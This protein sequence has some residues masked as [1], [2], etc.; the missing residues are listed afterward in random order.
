MNANASDQTFEAFLFLFMNH[1]E[2]GE[3]KKE[4]F[5]LFVFSAVK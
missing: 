4:V 2:S 5:A 1:K 3:H